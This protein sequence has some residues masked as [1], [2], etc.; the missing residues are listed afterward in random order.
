MIDI[1]PNERRDYTWITMSFIAWWNTNQS[2]VFC[3]GVPPEVQ[4]NIESGIQRD[5]R[6]FNS[7]DPFA[8]LAPVI[9][10]MVSLFDQSV[11]RI[12][13]QIRAVEVVRAIERE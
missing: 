7:H 10:E 8:L 3:F 1:N 9:D 2:L 11:W 6:Q 13:D 4:V 5:S 12:R